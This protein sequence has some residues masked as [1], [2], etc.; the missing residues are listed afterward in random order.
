MRTDSCSRRL[1]PLRTWDLLDTAMAPSGMALAQSGL[2]NGLAAVV[3]RLRH[4]FL[5][6][7]QHWHL[8]LVTTGDDLSGYHGPWDGERESVLGGAGEPM[9]S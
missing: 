4:T 5:S 9:S 8:G 6:D 2:E 1:Y 7:S 3:P